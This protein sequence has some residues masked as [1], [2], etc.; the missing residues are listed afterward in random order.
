VYKS[1]LIIPLLA[2]F[3]VGFNTEKV[4][5]FQKSDGVATTETDKTVELKIDKNTTEE[6][7][8]KMKKDLADNKIDFSYTTV[9]NEAREIID[10]SIQISG[11]NDKGES[12]SGNYASNSEGPINPLVIFY[13]DEA[14]LLSV[15][16]ATSHRIKINADGNH[17][18]LWSGMDEIGEHE[19]I[20]VIEKR[21]S[22][23]IIL[24]G[25]E[26]N[27]DSLQSKG[28][29][30]IVS[31]D[32]NDGSAEIHALSEEAEE[33]LEEKVLESINGKDD[34]ESVQLHFSSDEDEEGESDRQFK[35]KKKKSK[36]GKHVMIM[37]DSDDDSDIEVMN[38]DEG[39]FFI[40]T[41]G[42][43]PLYI[44][45]GKEASKKEVKKL[46]PKQIA[47]IDVSKGKAAIK[48]YGKKAKDGVVE[49]ITKKKN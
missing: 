45:D 13:D 33:V 16:D 26:I 46:S 42:K 9:R 22:K 43:D 27:K 32:E 31:V 2:L 25:R 49:I 34:L 28:F 18:M 38:S 40:D 47:T 29:N 35:I 10:I 11:K 14:N 30:Y 15:G 39:F 37:K 41:E 12:F 21:G 8:L 3:L 7:L 20:V 5:Q 17:T 6:A 36:K 1:F 48:K 19:D 44:I 23:K 24:N 4:Y